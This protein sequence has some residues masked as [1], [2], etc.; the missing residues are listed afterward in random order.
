MQP[1]PDLIVEPFDLVIFGGSGDLSMRK[2]LP[3]LYYHHR[4]RLLP[5]AGRVIAAARSPM[6]RQEFLAMAEENARRYIV[7]DAFDDVMWSQFAERLDYV[8]VDAGLADDFQTLKARLDEH[9]DRNRMFYLSTAP[10]LFGPICTHLSQLGLNA[11]PTRM[12]VEKPLGRNL[13][14]ARAINAQLGSVFD[15]DQ[16]Y[17]IDH[18][19]GKE[20]VQNLL[21]LRFGN[22][23]FEPL[24]RRGHLRDVQITV[25]EQIGVEGRGEFYDQTGALRDMVQN[26][27]LQMLSIIAME[28]PS[29]N[30]PDAVRDEKLKVLRAL[31]PITG[32][33]VALNT[34]RGQYRSGAVASTLVPGYREES[35]VPT[36][37]TTETFVAMRVH[38]DNWRWSGVPFY[39]RTGKRLQDRVTEIVM[40]FEPLPHE[41]FSNHPGLGST[42]NRLVIRLQP[43]EYIRLSI[44]A[45]APGDEMLLKPVDLNL[46]LQQAHTERQR[47]AYERLLIDLLRGRQTL[48]LRHDEMETAWG[49]VDPILEA[50]ERSSERPAQY[51]AGTWGPSAASQLIYERGGRWHEDTNL[52]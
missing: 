11:Q 5:E 27:M 3:S 28:P 26:H 31:R 29:D 14:T 30:T 10:S 24:W 37:S 8:K 41:I 23:L 47:S 15:E 33:D 42:P 17:R 40:N 51:T 21:A 35:G 46:D 12:A 25:A 20:P 2:L 32:A 39:L 7:A 44:C 13:E 22:A 6:T 45:K 50:W 48:F 52:W 1:T 36:G 18:Y 38:I 34:V 4:D 43:E 49:W 16:I 19:L 9:P